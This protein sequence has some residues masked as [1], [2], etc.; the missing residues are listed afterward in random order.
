M[1][2]RSFLTL[3]LVTT[4]ASLLRCHSE[5]VSSTRGGATA[6][7]NPP[8]AASLP[9]RSAPNVSRIAHVGPLQKPDALGLRLPKGFSARIVARSS[10]LVA[11]TRHRWHAAPDGGAAFRAPDGGHIYVSNCESSDDAGASA[12]C[13][14]ARGELVDAYPILRHTRVN[15]SGGP[16]PWGT[17]LSC[18]EHER[19]QVW[20]CD[21]TGRRPAVARPALGT[22]AH[23]AVTVDPIHHHVY[24]TEDVPDGRL[25][26]FTP[27]RLI[28][29]RPDLDA[30]TLHV[31]RVAK[32]GVGAV[33]WLPLPDPSGADRATRRQVP[34]STPFDGGEG[35]WWHQG[36]VY[37]TTKGDNR[38]WA[39]DVDKSELSILYDGAD[40]ELRGVD[41]VSVSAGGDVMVAEDGGD[42]Q[43][44]AISSD[45]GLVPLVQV[46]GQTQSEITGPA[47]D[48]SRTRLYFSSQRGPSGEAHGERGITY[49]ITGPFFV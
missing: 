3:G 17:W 28:D 35:I 15:C 26:R 22:F 32:D 25:Y 23:E 41:S 36:V 46:V 11:G 47:L 27:R 24:L 37:F 48:P 44:V 34:A 16:T 38:V 14:D 45:G 40:S 7:Q 49:E 33:E 2:R 9:A 20:E 12:L 1:L 19:G 6:T 42:M 43:L 8:T 10:E 18:E 39:Y 31:S 30:G 5:P 21:P 4:G 13:F 29:G